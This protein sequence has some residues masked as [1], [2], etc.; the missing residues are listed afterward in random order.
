MTAG[1]GDTLDGTYA[2]VRIGSPDEN[3]YAQFKGEFTFTGG[4]GKF[5]HTTSG[6]LR[7]TAVTSPSSLGATPPTVTAPSLGVA[8]YLVQGTMLSREKDD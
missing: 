3:G 1:N 5:R 4:T 2:A 8:F 6:V 7:F